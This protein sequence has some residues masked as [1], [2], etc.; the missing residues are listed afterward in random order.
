MGIDTEDIVKLS[1]EL[2][3]WECLPADSNIHVKGDNIRKVL[4]AID[5]SITELILA[6]SLDCD[7]VIAHHPLG[8]SSLDFHKVFD[9]HVDYMVENGIPLDQATET[10]RKLK[11]RVRLRS[12]ANIYDQIVHAAKI[13]NMPLVNI[14]QPCDEVMRRKILEKITSGS[15][16]HV[17]DI[18]KSIESIGEFKNVKTR[19]ET[20]FGSSNNR[21]G[22]WALVVAAGTNGGYPI[23]KLYFQHGIDTVIYLH[24]DYNDILKIQEEQL[25]GNLVIMGHLAG[26]SIG[27]NGLADK[28][29][30]KGIATVRL[31]IIPSI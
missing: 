14:H 24:I 18:I 9:R 26:D 3:N 17:S 29:E 21:V 6:K 5:A 15:T 12:H 23:A 25:R 22:R 28:L 31:G 2:V 11:E 8:I 27:L 30:E 1:L 7:A 16:E 4:I 20:V 13:M 19:V 10:T